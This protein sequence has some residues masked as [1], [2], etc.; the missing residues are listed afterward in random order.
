MF[1][2]N[3]GLVFSSFKNWIRAPKA[4]ERSVTSKAEPR[5]MAFSVKPFL[6]STP[7]LFSKKIIVPKRNVANA[8]VKYFAGFWPL[9]QSMEPAIRQKITVRR[10]EKIVIGT[11]MEYGRMMAAMTPTAFAASTPTENLNPFG[12]VSFK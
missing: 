10:T 11:E 8:K 9:A 6:G 4:M 12:V 3:F 1:G 7:S 5:M 2:I